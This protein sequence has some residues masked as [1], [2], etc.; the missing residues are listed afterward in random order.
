MTVHSFS[1]EKLDNP[2][3]SRAIS[4]K[5]RNKNSFRILCPVKMSF[6]ES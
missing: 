5:F 6:K 4:S 1:E 2:E 3:D